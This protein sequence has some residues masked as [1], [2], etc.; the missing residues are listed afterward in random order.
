MPN[1]NFAL[2]LMLAYAAELDV[3]IA[4]SPLKN[5]DSASLVRPA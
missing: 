4:H 5:F 2:R 1:V 3:S